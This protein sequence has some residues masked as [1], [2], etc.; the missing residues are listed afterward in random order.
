MDPGLVLFLSI[1]GALFFWLIVGSFGAYVSMEK[2]RPWYEGFLFAMFMGPLGVVAAACLP[3][4][5]AGPAD[6]PKPPS[7]L[8]RGGDDVDDPAELERFLKRR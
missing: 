4:L 6:P 3:E 8:T 7:F 1:L 5:V 2:G